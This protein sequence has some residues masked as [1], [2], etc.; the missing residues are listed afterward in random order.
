MKT[1][2]KRIEENEHRQ[3]TTI[4]IGDLYVSN[5]SMTI[6]T[7]LGSCVSVCLYDPNKNIGGINHILLPGEA[8]LK[9]YNACASY[10]INAMELLINKMI[11][12]GA[13]RKNLYAKIFGGGH[14]LGTISAQRGPGA[15]NT[16]F[17]REFLKMEN[18][19][20]ISED[21]GGNY[22]RK[23]Y[24]HPDTFEVFVKKMPSVLNNKILIDEQSFKKHFQYCLSH[25]E[26]TESPILL[27]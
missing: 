26:K 13:N 6:Y 1:M 17:A 19:P 15:K 8:D 9:R 14:I 11:K 10:G 18:I 16:T 3:M 25:P 5:K 22:I 20:I 2:N 27:N 4:H 24:F 23:L 7:V 12:M 21:T